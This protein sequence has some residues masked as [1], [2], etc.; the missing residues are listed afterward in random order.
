MNPA[1]RL[2]SHQFSRCSRRRKMDRLVSIF[3]WPFLFG[4]VSGPVDGQARAAKLL[5]LKLLPQES[6]FLAILQADGPMEHRVVEEKNRGERLVLDVLGVSNPLRHYYPENHPFLERILMYE[7][8]PATNPS[9]TG[10]LARVVFELKRDVS[11]Q[12]ESH[13]SELHVIFSEGATAPAQPTAPAE[14][15]NGDII[16]EAPAEAYDPLVPP[17]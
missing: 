13:A 17:R 5:A 3:I 2:V 14:N 7:Y 16:P 12:I 15:Q 8:P 9:L 11:Y 6:G 4:L 1:V 10:P